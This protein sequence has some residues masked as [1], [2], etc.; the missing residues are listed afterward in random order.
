MDRRGAALRPAAI[1]EMANILLAKRGSTPIQSIGQNWVYNF[2]KRHNKIKTRFS[3]RYDYRR[4][5]NKDPKIINKW[6]NCVRKT[7]DKNGILCDDIYNFDKT[8]FAIGL[9]ST[10]KVITRSKYYGRRSLLQPRNRE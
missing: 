6:F 2:I 3:R 10:A 8:S 4:A 5:K 1:R 9:A 7:V